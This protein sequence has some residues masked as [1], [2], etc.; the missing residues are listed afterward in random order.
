MKNKLN[1]I[2]IASCMLMATACSKGE[3]VDTDPEIDPI[4]GPGVETN[5]PNTTY[6][7]AFAGQTR[8]SAARTNTAF[9]G[10]AIATTLAAPWGI[11]ALPDGRLLI[12][13]KAGTM[14][15]ATTSGTLSNPITGLPAVN[16]N[17]QGGL[18][19]LC[20][21][22]QFSSNRMVYWVFS[23]NVAGGTQ[24]SVAK[25]RLAQ[26]ELTIENPTVIYRAGPAYNGTLHYGG[27]ILFDR[28]GNLIVSTGERS[29]LATRP[30][31]QSITAGLGKVIRINTS[32]Q[33]ATGN[34]TFTTS[35]ALPELYSIGHRN[36]QGLALH[37]VT[38]EI[39][40]SEHGPRGGDELN[41]LQGGRNY[42]WPTITY[43]IEYGGA[44]IGSAIQQQNG[45][46]QPT[47][48]WDPV[49]SPSGMTF[50]SGNRISEW[51]NNL[52]I[53]SLSATH[54]ARLIIVNNRVIGEERLLASEGQRFR[55][56]TQGTDNALYAV[57]DAGRLY[58]IDR[59]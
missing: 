6:A 22:P 35:G 55:D 59:P 10:I 38:G 20:I 58:R 24:T 47:Y 13:Q 26:N 12:T 15:I 42:G 33:P 45:L 31:A 52:F 49:I 48:Y 28:T 25:G 18:L 32:G 11:T 14:R 43:G 16:A 41:R 3:I 30:L 9:Q 29:D 34:P 17:G 56:I 5:P 8:I 7:P 21:D 27:R 39:W 54:I 57:T 50:Y 23:E 53:A 37:P 36:P 51:Q 1:L 40:Q 2:I 19:G 4:S 46:E 44:A